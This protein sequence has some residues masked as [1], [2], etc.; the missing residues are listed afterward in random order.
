MSPPVGVGRHSVIAYS[1]VTV[2]GG[3]SAPL[4]VIRWY[5][6]VQFEWQSMSVPMTPPD[7]APS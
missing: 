4:L 2:H 1:A 5:A 3:V 7:S 6:A